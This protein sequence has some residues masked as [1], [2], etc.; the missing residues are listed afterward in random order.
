MPFI[1][2][3]PLI[4][5]FGMC[6]FLQSYPKSPTACSS[7]GLGSSVSVGQ[8]VW[9]PALSFAS[10]RAPGMLDNGHLCHGVHIWRR[11]EWKLPPLV[12]HFEFSDTSCKRM[13]SKLWSPLHKS[14]CL[15]SLMFAKFF[16]FLQQTTPFIVTVFARTLPQE[17][18]C[19]LIQCWDRHKVCTFLLITLFASHSLHFLFFICG[20]DETKSTRDCLKEGLGAADC[21]V[22]A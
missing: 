13:D 9:A 5:F 11:K 1:L 4:L 3:K 8:L 19:P 18:L 20:E 14:R 17:S 6:R 12:K 15:I 21:W 22:E 7:L 16:L 2:N 10:S